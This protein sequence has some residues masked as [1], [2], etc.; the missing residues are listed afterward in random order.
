MSRTTRSLFKASAI[1]LC[2]ATVGLFSAAVQAAS[3]NYG[4][5]GPV[6]PG[7]SFLQVTE[8][9]GTDPVPLYGPPTPFSVGLDFNPIGFAASSSGGGADITDGQLNYTLTSGLGIASISV[10]ESGDY[11]IVGAGGAATGVGAGAIIIAT[12][13]EVNGVAVAPIGLAPVNAS[14]SD[15]LPGP[16]IVGPWSVG[17]T[18]NVSLPVGQR[19]TRVN[20][21]I[22]NTLVST[23]EAGTA[24][25]IAKK[26]FIVRSTTGIV[27]EPGTFALAGMVL[28]GL[29]LVRRK[30]S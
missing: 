3:I 9:S 20:V 27:P 24:A 5:F 17:A 6:A 2:L 26:E 16:V 22:N 11:T 29:G 18:L 4:N 8:S 23:S 25:F 15:S 7:V 21:V 30:S 14:F 19:A 10:S 12:V 13:T 28:C 1:A